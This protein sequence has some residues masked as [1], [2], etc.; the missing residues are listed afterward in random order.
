MTPFPGTEIWEIAKRRKKVSDNM[1]WDL[2]SHQNVN[3]PLLLDEDI[4]KKDFKEIFLK[5]KR[6]LRY[7]KYKKVKN[8]II[9]S[10]FQFFKKQILHPSSAIKVLSGRDVTR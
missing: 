7:F 9:R 3:N 6:K 10:P 5:A 1:D 4:D 2:L 8:D